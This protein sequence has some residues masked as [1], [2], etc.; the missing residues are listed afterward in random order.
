MIAAVALGI[1]L[2]AISAIAVLWFVG[3][4]DAEKL[5]RTEPKQCLPASLDTE[6]PHPGMLW[7]PGGRLRMGDTVYAEEGPIRERDVKGFWID[8]HEVTNREFAAFVAATGY[9]TVA[10][11]PV[12]AAA[13]PE[14]PA[15]MR[16]PGAVVFVMPNKV[17]GSGDISQWWQYIPRANWRHPG[18]P[19][20]N[21]DGHENYPVVAV[22]L[23]DIEAYARWKGR[24]IPDEAQWEW[25]ARGGSSR[26]LAEHE[27]PKEANTWQGIFPVLNSGD[28]GFVGLAPAGCYKPNGYGLYDMIGNVWEWTTDIYDGD[29][30]RRTIKGGSYLCAPNYCMRYRAG[31]RQGQEADLAT[32][33]L[34]FRTILE[35]PGP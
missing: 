6:G 25:A 9:V 7:V 12:D 11:R 31:A 8:R 28:D 2:I 34:G 26:P 29:A 23:A 4:R 19:R 33:H 5:A 13:H 17:D 27:Q 3:G 21:I 18:G 22:A 15:D 1:A 16:A 20:T 10:E 14:L 35:A 32:S 24:T 30:A